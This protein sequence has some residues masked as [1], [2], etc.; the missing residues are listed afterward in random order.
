MDKKNKAND[1]CIIGLSRCDFTFSSTRNCFISYGFQENRLE[2]T[3]LKRLLKDKEIEP[4]GAGSIAAL[5]HNAF[6]ARMCS[7]IITSKF[8]IILLNTDVNINIEYG[9]MIGFDKYVIP[10]QKESQPPPFDVAGLE[11]IKYNDED[12]EGKASVAIDL[13]IKQT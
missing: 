7:K 4:V 2:V 1:I 10:F 12:F 13:A 6:C 5:E 8:C 9:L 11:T 3:V